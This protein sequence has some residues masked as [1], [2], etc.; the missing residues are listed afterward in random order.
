MNTTNCQSPVLDLTYL[1]PPHPHHKP[2]SENAEFTH[3]DIMLQRSATV[4]PLPRL[5]GALSHATPSS[6]RLT[7]V[8]G[9][10]RDLSTARLSA[11][12]ARIRDSPANP[13]LHTRQARLFA[14]VAGALVKKAVYF[15]LTDLHTCRR[16]TKARAEAS[17]RQDIDCEQVF[18]QVTYIFICAYN[19]M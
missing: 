4:R 6:S 14:T 1:S 16:G 12:L 18:A 8:V 19:T 9:P 11:A 13:H 17:L 3:L 5:A 2:P 10:R 15:A 7:S